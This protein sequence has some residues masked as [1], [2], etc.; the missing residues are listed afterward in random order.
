MTVQEAIPGTSPPSLDANTGEIKELLSFLDGSIQVPEVRHHLWRSW[1]LC[2][3]HS[4]LSAVVEYEL[5]YRP[6]GTAILY[7]D[8]TS[9][10]ATVLSNP[11]RPRAVRVRQL[12]SRGAC[13]TCD[14][15]SIYRDRSE[16]RLEAQR[17]RANDRE[18]FSG[19]VADSRAEWLP[20][21]CPD[22][23]GGG[24]P[25]CRMH[26][27]EGSQPPLGPTA[28][29]LNDLAGRLERYFRSL[30]WQGPAASPADQSSW[31]E[32]LG[33]FSGRTYVEA[34]V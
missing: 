33:W 10:A 18:R 34:F 28:E 25:V 2:P 3:R 5:R 8:L 13:Y 11:L 15:L 16:P 14:Y 29:A 6:F 24:G 1:G 27:L 22:C 32:A 21:S 26:L 20:R 31:I 4:W 30:T 7:A 23:T 12:R 17:D 19:A 9:R